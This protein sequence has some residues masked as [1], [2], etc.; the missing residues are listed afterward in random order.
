MLFRGS[1]VADS[2]TTELDLLECTQSCTERSFEVPYVLKQT[3]MTRLLDPM[4]RT[5]ATLRVRLCATEYC[6]LKAHWNPG[7]GVLFVGRF[8]QT[9]FFERCGQALFQFDLRQAIGEV[10]FPGF[11]VCSK[12]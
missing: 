11:R 6:R 2:T 7:G 9:C 3:R 8:G 1:G 4:T 5:G 10:P 12:L